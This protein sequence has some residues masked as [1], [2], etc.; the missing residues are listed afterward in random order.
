MR[1][2]SLDFA[3]RAIL[4][5]S[6]FAPG[7]L[8]LRAKEKAPK[9]KGTRSPRRL[10]PMPCVPRQ[11]GGAHNSVDLLMSASDR[12]RTFSPGWLRYSARPT[13]QEASSLN[14][15]APPGIAGKTGSSEAMSGR[16]ER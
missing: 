7:E 1:S 14:P 16:I 11:S 3:L 2:P 10:T 4:R 8:V 5:M 6:Q 13:G 15:L 9:E 12:M